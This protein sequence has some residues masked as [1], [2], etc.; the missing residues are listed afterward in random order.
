MIILAII[1]VVVL[2]RVVLLMFPE[3]RF[4][5]KRM[6]KLTSKEK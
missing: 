6:D 5:S 4:W 2:F 1:L 3:I